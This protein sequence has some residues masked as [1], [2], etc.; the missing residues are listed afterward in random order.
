MPAGRHRRRTPHGARRPATWALALVTL[1][2]T[3]P[4][5][6]A[7]PAA[8]RPGAASAD[9]W[10]PDRASDGM[11][12]D[13]SLS[14]R[15]LSDGPSA[16]RHSAD[17]PSDSAASD[18]PAPSRAAL[19]GADPAW[20]ADGAASLTPGTNLPL[21]PAVLGRG[22]RLD[23]RRAEAAARD[24]PAVAL[25]AY[26]AAA[27]DLAATRPGC[28]LSWTVL[29][30]IGRI[31]SDHAHGGAVSPDGTAR[32][33]ILG[34]LLNG[35]HGLAAVHDTDHGRW[36]H[37]SRWDRA[38]GPMQFLP[39]TWRA[40]GVSTRRGAAADP[41]NLPDAAVTAG[42][43]LCADHRDLGT[44]RGLAAAVLSYDHSGG[45][46]AAVRRWS[47]AYRSAYGA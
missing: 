31:E 16:R 33:D 37:N 6:A 17:A 10:S 35:S 22:P 46:L 11:S 32:R 15:S 1:S 3:A 2:A 36:D 5:A 14:D 13:L 40:W 20:S 43:Y 28:H 18:L 27:Q 21:P 45:Y 38:V 42:R 26:R 12:A 8:V 29:A 7:A 39:A 44:D 30:A 9:G 4:G 34:P 19:R 25:R 41:E 23:R 47:A 24:I